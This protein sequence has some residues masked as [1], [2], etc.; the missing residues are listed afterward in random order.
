MH[1]SSFTVPVVAQI[2]VTFYYTA[3]PW[4]QDFCSRVTKLIVCPTH[5]GNFVSDTLISL[6]NTRGMSAKCSLII[7]V[8]LIFIFGGFADGGID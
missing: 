1:L 8:K 2:I 6:D 3:G 4:W 5:L 7:S